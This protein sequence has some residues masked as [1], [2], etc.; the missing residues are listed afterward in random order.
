MDPVDPAGSVAKADSGL[1]EG[2]AGL[3]D[4]AD[5]E[6]RADSADSADLAVTEDSKDRG[7]REWFLASRCPASSRCPSVCMRVPHRPRLEIVPRPCR[8]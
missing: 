7:G 8:H 6:A 5:S 2:L 3:A 1:P 4:W